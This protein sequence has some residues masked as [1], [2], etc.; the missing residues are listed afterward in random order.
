M[1]VY[2]V[3]Q[4][5][6]RGDSQATCFRPGDTLRFSAPSARPSLRTFSA[7]RERSRSCHT[8]VET[9]RFL[10]GQKIELTGHP[11]Y[12]SDLAP[13]DSYLFP[14]V[15]NKLRGQRISRREEAVDAFGDTSIRMEKV[16]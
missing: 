8:S 6:S 13:N 1:S 16:L 12:N 10:E 7:S 11:P 2:G 15:K 3:A 9:I 4:S 5:T 14:S